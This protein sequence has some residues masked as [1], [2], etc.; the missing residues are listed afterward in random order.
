MLPLGI[1]TL[2]QIEAE[3]DLVRRVRDAG[4]L[5]KFLLAHF[6]PDAA[7]DHGRRDLDLA[8]RVKRNEKLFADGMPDLLHAIQ[9]GEAAA[10][11]EP[12][13]D[14]AKKRA[15]V[16]LLHAARTVL[17]HLPDELCREIHGAPPEPP[18]PRGQ[19]PGVGDQTEALTRAALLR[20]LLKFAR[21][22]VFVVIAGAVVF[23]AVKLPALLAETPADVQARQLREQAKREEAAKKEAANAVRAEIGVLVDR[24]RRSHS[25]AEQLVRE[26]ETYEHDT[27]PLLRND[28]GRTLAADA[29]G[30]ETL[31]VLL[32][33]PRP[34]LDEA[35]TLRDR[36]ERDLVRPLAE[37]YK[38]NPPL[39]ADPS[40]GTHIDE[41]LAQATTG[42]SAY[43]ALSAA[44]AALSA[45]TPDQQVQ[46]TGNSALDGL[47]AQPSGPA[48]TLEEAVN[49]VRHRHTRAQQQTVL[50]AAAKEREAAAARIAE[51][52]AAKTRAAA[53]AETQRKRAEAAAKQR[54]AEQVKA[55]AE[56]E[57]LRAQ[58]R[59][60]KIIS[61]FSQFLSPGHVYFLR[62]GD[63]RWY[64][65]DIARPMSYSM[66]KDFGATS[67][68]RVFAAIAAKRDYEDR[69]GGG[70]RATSFSRNDRPGVWAY[71]S[72]EAG[73][74]E[75]K[76]RMRVF[77]LLAPYWIEQGKLLK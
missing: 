48:P 5:L 61:A 67:D 71:P 68:W 33:K 53:E 9:A 63:E 28:K 27:Q 58:A 35:T 59:D 17:P 31:A 66:L 32:D 7:D 64:R 41:A 8:T 49:A 24:A 29:T 45:T 52:E 21:L 30:V 46:S 20:D 74:D 4:V 47:I 72:T 50:D 39:A 57:R 56:A 6:E 3:R 36:I 13:L 15:A 10:R 65:S 73:V 14:A 2:P 38:A 16:T 55:R 11:G 54:E 25:A 34:T 70:Y 18:Q 19:A 23:G 26:I 40:R 77:E 69:S 60:P 12:L 1:R 42:L 37:A 76:K 43:R 75:I 62:N 22:A 44:F 51:A